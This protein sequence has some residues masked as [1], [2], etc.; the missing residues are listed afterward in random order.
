LEADE[1]SSSDLV[2]LSI[3]TDTYFLYDLYNDFEILNEFDYKFYN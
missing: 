3:D 2:P 1:M